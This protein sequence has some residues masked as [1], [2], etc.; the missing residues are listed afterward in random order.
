[1]ISH[2]ALRAGN[3]HIKPA[4][5]QNNWKHRPI[6]RDF[7]CVLLAENLTFVV[8]IHS[9]QLWFDFWTHHRKKRQLLSDQRI[10]SYRQFRSSAS[11]TY[12]PGRD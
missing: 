11:F 12:R 9:K 3:S 5:Q 7:F 1:M 6:F 4:T 2:P 8:K 10:Y